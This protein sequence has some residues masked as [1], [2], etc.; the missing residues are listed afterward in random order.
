M[1]V[2][3][4]RLEEFATNCLLQVGL[5]ETESRQAAVALVTTDS[6]GVHTHGLKNLRGYIRRLREG[7]LNPKA[8][9]Q[10]ERQG[11]AWAILNAHSA[12]AMNS[13][14][15]A[16]DLAIEK[17]LQ[18]GIG[19][20]GVHNS[21][22]FGAAGIYA[23]RAA[24]KGLIGIAMANDT[25]TVSVPGSRTAVLGSNPLA[26]SIPTSEPFPFLLDIATSTVA[27]GKVFQAATAGQSVPEGWIIDNQGLP[28]TD[29][30]LFPDNACLTPMSGHKGYGIAFWIETL[31]AVMTGAA[32]GNHVLSWSFAPGHQHTQHGAAFIAMDVNSILPR[33]EFDRRIAELIHQV[34]SAPLALN[35]A[36]IQIPGEREWRNRQHAI[37]HGLDLP[38][39]VQAPLN[40]LA[41]ETGLEWNEPASS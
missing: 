2:R 40:Q 21:C 27:G 41:L 8:K 29:P 32:I 1:S 9:P 20:V 39:D 7:G 3:L 28:T 31:S 37:L 15:C 24:A 33:E 30:R 5:S 4:E 34:R 13:S 12:L 6:W 23:S 17:A 14:I 19:Y 22:H 16:M 35:A 36:L 11:P 25:P 38:Q 10:I 18:C 26:I